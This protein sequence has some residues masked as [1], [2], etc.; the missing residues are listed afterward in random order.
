MAW[1]P[2]NLV[3]G[4]LAVSG[5]TIVL[6]LV[7]GFLPSRTRRWLRARLPRRLRGPAGPDAPERP[8]V[9]FDPPMLTVP[10]VPDPPRPDRSLPE[11]A[12]VSDPSSQSNAAVLA[13]LDSAAAPGQLDRSGGMAEPGNEGP[14]TRKRGRAA[15]RAVA[16]GVV[17][18]LVAALVVPLWAALV[19]ACVVVA[20]LYLPWARG[21]ATAGGV[22]LVAAGCAFVV[23]GQEVH[24]YLS[25]SNWPSSF[26]GAGD[27]IWLGV[28]LL[29]ADAVISVFR[30]RLPRPLGPP[31]LQAGRPAPATGEPN[32][33]GP[34]VRAPEDAGYDEGPP[35]DS[36]PEGAQPEG[37]EPENDP[38]EAPVLVPEAQSPRTPRGV[39][40]VES[41]GLA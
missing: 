10:F 12:P 33:S 18:G 39:S 6:C 21:V 28:V 23:Y 25:G 5:A 37:P 3:W 13:M 15:L 24:R 16:I 32:G 20:G 19:V 31:S 7:L 36:Q 11:A 35:D 8:S 41:D 38:E 40:E 17:T 9:P 14:P 34:E 22:A 1:T 26:T 2:Q 29:L 30:L 4:A 27:L